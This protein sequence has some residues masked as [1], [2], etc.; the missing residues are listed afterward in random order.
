MVFLL[1]LMIL[2]V[3][4]VMTYLAFTFKKDIDVQTSAYEKIMKDHANIDTQIGDTVDVE[5][6]DRVSNVGYVVGQVNSVN[7]DIYKAYTSNTSLINSNA[8]YAT[9]NIARID[10]TVSGLKAQQDQMQGGFSKFLAFSS[11][12]APGAPDV[13]LANL[14]GSSAPD[15]RLIQHVSATMGLTAKDLAPGNNAARFCNSAGK[16]IE[17]PNQN[18]DTYLT[19]FGNGKVVLD[20]PT[21]VGGDLSLP[22]NWKIKSDNNQLCFEHGNNK[23][24]CISDGVDKVRVF[25]NSD[26]NSPYMFFNNNGNIGVYPDGV[27]SLKLNNKWSIQANGADLVAHDDSAGTDNKFQ[28]VAGPVPQP[29]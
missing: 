20:A 17:F 8:T 24:A 11:S 22:G 26:G 23:V 12:T 4:A 1:V 29:K 28:F 25:Q 7:D 10:N 16:C 21:A 9:S 5:R 2:A 3:A 19:G 6:K 18:G 13:T 14:A 15:V 27:G